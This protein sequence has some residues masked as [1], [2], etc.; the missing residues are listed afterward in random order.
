MTN[1]QRK[2]CTLHGQ[3]DD[4]VVQ[5]IT[6]EGIGY[7]LAREL[8]AEGTLTSITRLRGVAV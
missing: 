2:L 8:V 1:Y 3:M 4:N 5:N 7:L 6:S